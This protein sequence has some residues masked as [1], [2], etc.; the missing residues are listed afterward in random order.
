VNK[1][2]TGREIVQVFKYREGSEIQTERGWKFVKMEGG[3]IRITGT[4]S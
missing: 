2:T 3:G 4:R 1:V